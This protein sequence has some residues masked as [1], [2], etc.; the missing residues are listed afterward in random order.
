MTL[1]RKLLIA[2]LF[3]VLAFLAFIG[4]EYVYL[5]RHIPEAYM[6]WDTGTLLVEYMKTHNDKWP[7]SWEDL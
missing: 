6:A 5:N 2:A 3:L 7:S 4:Y 1:R